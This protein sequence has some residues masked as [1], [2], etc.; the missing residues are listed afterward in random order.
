MATA[1]I[2]AKRAAAR[3]LAVMLRSWA[4]FGALLILATSGGT[5]RAHSFNVGFVAPLSGARAQD[6]KRALDGFLLATAEQDGH[7][8]Q[9][10]DG[11]LGGV[12]SN[13]LTVDAGEGIEAVQQRLRE[14]MREK[15][16][17]FVTGILAPEWRASVAAALVQTRVIVVDPTDS[18]AF[19]SAA[20]TTG[21]ITTM[22]GRAFPEV[23]RKAYGYQ[24]DEFA[25]RGYIAAR[26][27]AAAIRAEGG[28]ANS[29]ALRGAVER[30]RASLD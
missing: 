12:D 24:P 2:V 15:D 28:V 25:I 1:D 8:A 14:L 27:I 20:G 30:A 10:S 11:H 13:V 3:W 19:R 6:G 21:R 5:A 17:V 7:A 18:A 16:L 4:A 9:T 23:F 26:I 22:D 29:D